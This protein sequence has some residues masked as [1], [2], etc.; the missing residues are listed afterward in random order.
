M[1][2]AFAIV[3]GFF[4]IVSGVAQHFLYSESA[5]VSKPPSTSRLPP[6]DQHEKMNFVY[7]SY[8]GDDYDNSQMISQS[9]DV[10]EDEIEDPYLAEQRELELQ[11]QEMERQEQER[12]ELIIK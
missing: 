5:V 12:Q 9:R 7:F 11:R 4:V 2:G 10:R 8:G 1:M 6:T 3:V